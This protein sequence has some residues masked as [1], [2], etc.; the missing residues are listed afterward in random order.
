MARAQHANLAIATGW[1]TTTQGADNDHGDRDSNMEGTFVERCH[2]L[3]KGMIVVV[4]TAAAT[5]VAVMAAVIVMVVAAV[6][7][8]AVATI[9]MVE[10]VAVVVAVVAEMAV[11]VTTWRCRYVCW[12]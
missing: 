11:A 6:P 7:A 3:V 5:V 10:V 1:M 12:R 9:V 8:A 4:V 2:L